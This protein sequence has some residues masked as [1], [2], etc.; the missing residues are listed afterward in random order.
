M[1]YGLRGLGSRGRGSSRGGYVPSG[2]TGE[3]CAGRST[4][5]SQSAGSHEVREMRNA[6]MALTLYVTTGER[7]DTETVMRRSERGGWK[8]VTE[9][10]RWSPT[11]RHA[12]FCRPAEGAIPSLSLTT[13]IS[14]LVSGSRTCNGLSP[15]A[16]LNGSSLPTVPLP[17][18][19]A[20][21]GIGWLRLRTVK[22]YGKDYKSGR[23]SRS[24]PWPPE[25]RKRR[26][27]SP[28]SWDCI[29]TNKLTKPELIFPSQFLKRLSEQG[30]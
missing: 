26:D 21:T 6:E 22:N 16:T 8:S 3:P 10:T 12:R 7:R 18:T 13:P 28:S 4:T 25:G 19:S 15:P 29:S 14:P 1:A 5:G 23:R 2:R 11:L 30:V 9:V 17:S 27:A 24:Q 20:R